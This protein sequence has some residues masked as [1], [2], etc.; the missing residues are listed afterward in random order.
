MNNGIEISNNEILINQIIDKIKKNRISTT[1]IADVLGKHGNIADVTPVNRGHFR[2]GKVFLAYA[3]EESNWELHDQLQNVEEG[4][5]VIVETFKCDNRAVFG[6]L[7]SKYLTLYRSAAAIVVNGYMRDVARLL[8]ENYPIW[9]KGVTPIGCFNRINEQPLDEAI[10]N[11]WKEKYEGS[12]AVCDDA[13]VVVIPKHEINEDFL[14][15]LDFIELQEDI[16]YHCMDT[17]KWSTYDTVCLKKY[18]DTSLLPFELK[19]KF[20]DFTKEQ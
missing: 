19:K 6:D 12:I 8:K 15:K 7:V 2:V 3:Y 16:W 11:V 20:E 1:E 13:G 17:K 14:S 5:I 18:K 4:D 10:I 9:C